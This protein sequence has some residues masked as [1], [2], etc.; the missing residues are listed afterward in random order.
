MFVLSRKELISYQLRAK[1]IELLR[2]D[3]L[4]S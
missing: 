2:Q 4:L 3:I 1:Q